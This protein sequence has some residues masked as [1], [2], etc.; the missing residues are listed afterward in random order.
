MQDLPCPTAQGQ[1]AKIKNQETRPQSDPTEVVKKIVPGMQIE[2][3]PDRAHSTGP[4][5]T[6]TTPVSDKDVGCRA[7]YTIERVITEYID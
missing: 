7:Q 4:A 1:H 2:V 5:A 6:W 3:Q